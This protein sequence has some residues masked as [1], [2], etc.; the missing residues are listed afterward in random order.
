MRLKTLHYN[1]T[2]CTPHAA[3]ATPLNL[4][5]VPS[6]ILGEGRF[7]KVMTDFGIHYN[8][9]IH[10]HTEFHVFARRRLLADEAISAARLRLARR[11]LPKPCTDEFIQIAV[12]HRLHIPGFIVGA[13]ILH[14]L[15]GM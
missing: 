2:P 11:P 8:G 10:I 13:Q 9:C 6:P 12:Q 5:P 15:I 1:I 7:D 4:T 14:Q 3:A